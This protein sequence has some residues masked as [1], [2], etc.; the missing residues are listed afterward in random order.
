[1]HAYRQR[2]LE[3]GKESGAARARPRARPPLS[4]ISGCDLSPLPAESNCTYFKFFTSGENA[5]IFKKTT[6][7]SE[8]SSPLLLHRL[9]PRAQ[10]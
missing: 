7:N 6:H 8:P 2:R 10:G 5:V 4:F 9:M 3:Q 1:M